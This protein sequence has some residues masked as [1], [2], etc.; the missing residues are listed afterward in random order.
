MERNR[1]VCWNEIQSKLGAA[2][3]QAFSQKGRLKSKLQKFDSQ[4]SSTLD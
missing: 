3:V 2:R 4:E 1:P